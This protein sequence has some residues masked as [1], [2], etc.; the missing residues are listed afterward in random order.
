MI[1]SVK[2]LD[3]FLSKYNLF[4]LGT[5]D[6]YRKLM[7]VSSLD[8]QLPTLSKFIWFCSENV[9]QQDVLNKLEK[10]LPQ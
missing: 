10:F 1:V 8:V 9:T 2:K 6:L 3:E 4:T 7:Y 5:P